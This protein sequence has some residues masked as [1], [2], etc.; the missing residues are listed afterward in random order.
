[1]LFVVSIVIDVCVI[2]RRMMEVTDTTRHVFIGIAVI[3]GFM[4]PVQV[5]LVT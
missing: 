3:S 1:M 2:C 5:L 4:V